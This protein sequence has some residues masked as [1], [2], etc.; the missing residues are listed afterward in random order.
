MAEEQAK[1]NPLPADEYA[2]LIPEDDYT[3]SDAD[4]ELDQAV[5]GIDI[6]DA[7]RK[8]CGKMEP[9]ISKGQRENIMI[10][11]PMPHHADKNPSAA[12]NLD[13]QVWSCYACGTG[14]DAHDLAAMH[15]GYDVPGYKKD[16]SFSKLR[17]QMAEDFGYRFERSAITG[18][19][20]VV[21]PEE[22]EPVAAPKAL[23]APSVPDPTLAPVVSIAPEPAVEESAFGPTVDWQKIVPRGTFLDVYMHQTVIDDNPEE[24]HFWNGLIA[25]GFALGQ[26]ARLNDLNPVFGNLFVCIIANSGTG[27]SKS[28]KHLNT[29]LSRA[30]P[31]DKVEAENRG[32]NRVKSPASAETLINHFAKPIADPANP[33]MTLY[34]AP[35]SGLIEFNELSQLTGRANRQGNVLKPTLMQF[36]DM[37]EIISTTSMT[38]GEKHAEKPFGSALTTSQ[39]RALRTLMSRADDDSG[40]LNRWIF[41][42][43]RG[44]KQIAIGGRV[45]DVEPAVKPLQRILGWS[46]TFGDDDYVEWGPEAFDKFTEFFH[47][48]LLPKKIAASEENSLLVRIDLT[49]K[50]LI[51]LLSANKLERVVT[52]ETI[53]EAIALYPYL[54]ECYGVPAREINKTDESM[55]QEDIIELLKRKKESPQSAHEVSRALSRRHD[56]SQIKKAIETLHALGEVEVVEK[57]AGAKGRPTERYRYVG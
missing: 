51:L 8:W 43:G 57:P 26:N 15:Y 21:P 7:Y 56:R 25:L 19:T 23:P 28:V 35:V 27:K 6:V 50:K 38:T 33:K 1:A 5:D 24:F 12:I 37:D 2:D 16:G 54:L 52:G 30:L 13:K 53:D 31:F 55:V 40:F 11:C 36:Y 9:K 44:K 32:V 39:P 10:S 18:I 47:D 49:M 22:P 48:T 41:V 14:G 17:K 4:V 3:L 42:A 20:Y 34:Y 45:V 29:L 46:G